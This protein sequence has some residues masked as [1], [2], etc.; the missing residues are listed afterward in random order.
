MMTSWNG[1]IFCTTC[2]M[3]GEFNG[4][5]NNCETRDLRPHRGHYDVTVMALIPLCHFQGSLDALYI[6]S[7]AWQYDIKLHQSPS[8]TGASYTNSLPI[9]LSNNI[10]RATVLFMHFLLFIHFVMETYS[11]S[12]YKWSHKRN[13]QMHALWKTFDFLAGLLLI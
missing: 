11:L 4:W 1:N 8:D 5:I 7:H 2:H 3:C 12:K 10:A 6:A 9:L 13:L